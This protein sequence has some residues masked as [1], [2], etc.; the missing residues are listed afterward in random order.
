[1][2]LVTRYFPNRVHTSILTALP[3]VVRFLVNN[4]PTLTGPGWSIIEAF[5]SSSASREVPSNSASVSSLATATSWISGP[6]G[7]GDWIVLESANGNNTNHFQLYM[8]ADAST[9]LHVLLIPLCNFV[10][11]G[12]AVTPPTFPTTSLGSGTSVPVTIPCIATQMKI[13]VVADQGMMAFIHDT[14]INSETV[15]TYVGELNGA[16]ENGSPADD[17]CYVIHDSPTALEWDEGVNDNALRFWNRLSPV[18]DSTML[19]GT[20]NGGASAFVGEPNSP[21]LPIHSEAE[22]DMTLGVDSILPVGVNFGIGIHR[23]FAGFLRNVYSVHRGLGTVGQLNDRAFIYR[24]VG[25][26]LHAGICFKWD[27]TTLYP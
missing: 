12:S 16:R 20:T 17:R 23:H 3:D 25:N 1:M 24:N 19:S 14:G 5:T 7:A 22:R 21:H 2:A 10:T 11:G 6:L 18:D 13:S 9:R 4:H 27:G 26:Q 8:E 15:W